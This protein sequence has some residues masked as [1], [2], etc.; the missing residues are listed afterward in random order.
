M[1]TLMAGMS[2]GMSE[3]CGA[4]IL[5]VTANVGSLFEDTENLQKVWLK[6]FFE[7]V[8]AFK[9]HFLALHCQEC[10]GKS[11]LLSLKPV[12]YFIEALISSDELTDY[13]RARI[14][15]DK[16]QESPEYYTALGSFYFIHE[17]VKSVS[18]FDFDDGKFRKVIGRDV[19]IMS[20]DRLSLPMVQKEK[21]PADFF[22]QCQS[23]RKGF[24]R[25]RWGLSNCD[26]DLVNVHL[27]HDAHNVMA[28]KDSPSS[29]AGIRQKAVSF[30]LQRLSDEKYKKVPFFL[31]GDFNFRLDA[32]PL[33][34]HL[35]SSSTLEVITDT[36]Y[37]KLMF[38]ETNN[39]R[40]VVLEVEK[41][42]FNYI[43]PNVF[44]ANNGTSLLQFDKELS[45]FK[46]Q[47]D[48]M[49][50]TFPPTYPYS[51]DLSHAK[52]YNT[53]RCPAWCDR[54]LMST[55]AK[56]LIAKPEDGKKEGE[57]EN[58]ENAIVYDNI[59]PNVCMGDHKPVFLS[60]RLPA[61]K[62]NPYACSCRCCVVQ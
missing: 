57:Q 6:E 37:D 59:G 15:I 30:I 40:K 39:D 14:Y 29:Y 4:K 5:L 55:S 13:N 2:A 28:W 35:C 10:G 19:G 51:E 27:F 33:F 42:T 44:Q 1:A 47:L 11:S 25:T 8:K 3:E 53:T 34:E 20:P 46:D 49:E 9:P 12:N 43:N 32:K 31:F 52:Q 38:R 48:E 61:G 50:I 16:T 24:L 56:C 60:F 7:T 21:F 22:P 45:M 58:E 18:E 36:N 41:K 26:F 54:I 62:G 17:S 23:S